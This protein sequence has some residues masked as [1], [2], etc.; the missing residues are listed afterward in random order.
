MLSNLHKLPI[1]LAQ[2]TLISIAY[3]LSTE[4]GEIQDLLS[5]GSAA[6]QIS[7]C[8]GKPRKPQ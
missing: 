7:A 5:K 8:D 6:Q 2:A 3:W 1:N 4:A